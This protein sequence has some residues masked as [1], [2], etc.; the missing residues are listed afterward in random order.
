M[1][2]L[3]E[4]A[5]KTA[6]AKFLARKGSHA[7]ATPNNVQLAMDIG[8]SLSLLLSM[9]CLSFA[10]NT[11]SSYQPSAAKIPCNACCLPPKLV[12]SVCD[13]L[14]GRGEIEPLARFLRSLPACDQIQKNES[15]L[16]AKAFIAFHQG[17][18]QELYRIIEIMHPSH[19]RMQQLW[20]QAQ[21]ITKYR[22][23]FP[24]PRAI[25]DGEGEETSRCTEE[26]SV[27][28]LRQWYVQNPYP[29]PREKR[30][31]AEQTGLTTAQVSNWFKNR[32]KM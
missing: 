6:A 13:D 21:Y 31:L 12:A 23:K 14:Q 26:K 5:R 25:W 28:I 10:R 32:R 30:Q 4:F 16:K 18:F 11:M 9:Q 29:S 20:L 7:H 17:N 19:S 1:H 22:R 3:L 15:V 2:G 8:F 24:L 27:V